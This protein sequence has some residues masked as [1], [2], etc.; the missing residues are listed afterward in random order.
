MYEP[1][2][3]VNGDVIDEVDM[4]RIEQGIAALSPQPSYLIP[5]ANA[6]MYNLRDFGAGRGLGTTL[7]GV[8]AMPYGVGFHCSVDRIFANVRTAGAAGA[9]V[10]TAIYT[11]HPT[12]HMPDAL[13]RDMGTFGAATSGNKEVTYTATDLA[14]ALYWV[15]FAI[16]GD[17]STGVSLGAG[18][19]ASHPVP[20]VPHSNDYTPISCGLESSAAGI[21]GAFPATWTA[22][23][24]V[25]NGAEAVSFALVTV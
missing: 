8:L 21:T 11:A 5:R 20:K 23:L 18:N 17:A 6:Y 10:R 3:W 22:S 24:S 16:Q 9:V 25:I 13:V 12:T 2:D 7:G 19:I 15:L 1:R 4:D 14:P